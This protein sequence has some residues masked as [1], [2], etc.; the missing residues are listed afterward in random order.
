MRPMTIKWVQLHRKIG[1]LT[2]MWKMAWKTLFPFN[3][4]TSTSIL[5]SQSVMYGTLLSHG[6]SRGLEMN[7][8]LGTECLVSVLSTS[9]IDP[10]MCSNHPAN[11]AKHP[12]STSETLLPRSLDLWARSTMPG[13]NLFSVIHVELHQQMLL[14]IPHQDCRA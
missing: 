14:T 11:H 6:P 12:V 2:R 8:P 3:Q 9:W 1:T 7:S 13:L 10:N 4:E 5:V